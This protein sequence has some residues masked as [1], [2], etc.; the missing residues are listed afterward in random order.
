MFVFPF[1]YEPMRCFAQTS[2]EIK[3]CKILTK[4]YKDKTCPF[5][6]AE[7]DYTNGVRYPF[8]EIKK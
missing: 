4:T 2:G 5:C 3:R 8:K 1:C 6:K 7:R